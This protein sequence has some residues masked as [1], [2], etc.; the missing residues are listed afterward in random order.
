[1]IKEVHEHRGKTTDGDHHHVCESRTK[2]ACKLCRPG[3]STIN[4]HASKTLRRTSV[5]DVDDGHSEKVVLGNIF[6]VSIRFVYKDLSGFIG[7]DG[8]ER[9]MREKGGEKPYNR[10]WTDCTLCWRKE[11]EFQTVS[12]K[13]R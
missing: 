1:M 9:P 7:W 11:V 8:E 10:I 13:V 6:D 5:A 4:S 12:Q 2:M 3:I